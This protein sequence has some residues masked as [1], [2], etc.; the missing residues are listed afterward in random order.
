MGI[1]RLFTTENWKAHPSLNSYSH[2]IGN[3]DKNKP[4][5][6]PLGDDSG[7]TREV[8]HSMNTLQ[9]V[10]AS[11]YLYGDSRVWKFSFRSIWFLKSWKFGVIWSSFRNCLWILK[12]KKQIGVSKRKK[13]SALISFYCCKLFNSNQNQWSVR[14]VIPFCFLKTFL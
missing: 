14:V 2:G 9:V 1:F 8:L 6:L 3:L 7:V 10:A 12:A 5:W 11:E 4:S 13:F